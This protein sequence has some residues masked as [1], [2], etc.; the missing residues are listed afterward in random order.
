M[1]FT[2]RGNEVDMDINKL[3]GKIIYRNM[4]IADNLQITYCH[5]SPA[6]VDLSLQPRVTRGDL[7]IFD[8]VTISIDSSFPIVNSVACK[9]LKMSLDGV[10]EVGSNLDIRIPNKATVHIID[11]K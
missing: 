4:F 6:I 5:P 2:Y 9:M 3:N 11:T 10:I 8:E 7:I 1:E